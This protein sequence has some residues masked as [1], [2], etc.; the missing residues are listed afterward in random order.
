MD[1][2]EQRRQKEI[3]KALGERIRTLRQKRK[4]WSSQQAFADACGMSVDTLGQ[5]ER[6]ETNTRLSV[7]MRIAR[8][9]NVSVSR[10]FQDIF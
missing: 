2:K 3:R 4:R 1:A 7:M 5:I 10:L 9:L 6:G 8:S